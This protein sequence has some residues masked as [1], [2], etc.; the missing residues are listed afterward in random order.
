M[1]RSSWRNITQINKICVEYD[2][3][4][5]ELFANDEEYEK[6]TPLNTHSEHNYKEDEY[7]MEI[8]EEDTNNQS[9]DLPRTGPTTQELNHLQGI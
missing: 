8:V 1:T 3:N 4:F 9:T 6:N 2:K 7:D 5:D